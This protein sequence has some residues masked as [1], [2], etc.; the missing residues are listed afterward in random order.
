MIFRYVIIWVLM[1]TEYRNSDS[2]AIISVLTYGMIA[3]ALVADRPRFPKL[4]GN[5]LLYAAL[6]VTAIAMARTNNEELNAISALLRL[7]KLLAF[8]SISF[9]VASKIQGKQLVYIPAAFVLLNLA[10]YIANAD[11]FDNVRKAPH[12]GESVTLNL[13][14]G[15]YAD[16]VNFPLVSGLNNYGMYIGGVMALALCRRVWWIAGVCLACLVLVDSRAVIV[17]SLASVAMAYASQRWGLKRLL[18]IACCALPILVLINAYLLPDNVITQAIS[19]SD[20]D[21]SSGNSRMGI[22]S[23]CLLSLTSFT[24]LQLIGYGE[25]GQIGSGIINNWSGDFAASFN[26]TS[27]ISTHNLMLQYIFDIGYLGLAVLLWFILSRVKRTQSVP[28]VAFILY[29]LLAGGTEAHQLQILSA[30]F[31]WYIIAFSYQ[32]TIHEAKPTNNRAYFANPKKY[33]NWPYA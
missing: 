8:I 13:L 17:T 26:D 20:D 6:A 29:Y 15:L 5:W 30:T 14:T 21:I 33:L 7:C 10:A 22:W 3:W 25:F 18:V 4:H 1:V 32:S 23:I 24:P 28:A 9:T 12:L 11:L 16:R 2:S 31:F 27:V 19:R